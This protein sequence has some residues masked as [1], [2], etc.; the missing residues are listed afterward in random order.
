[1]IQFFSLPLVS[2]FFF[3][4][5]ISKIQQNGKIHQYSNNIRMCFAYYSI[6]NL[7]ILQYTTPFLLFNS[8]RNS[9]RLFTVSKW[10]VKSWKQNLPQ[11][12]YASHVQWTHE[13]RFKGFN[14][15]LTDMC[16]NPSLLG[17]II[18]LDI[19]TIHFD[20]IKVF[21]GRCGQF[22]LKTNVASHECVTSR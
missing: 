6:T 19:Y 10:I 3:F 12:C 14:F 7:L 16:S 2:F 4:W 20:D 17:E 9:A 21:F 5:I 13:N 11:R 8:W 18:R 15:G 22:H 1:M